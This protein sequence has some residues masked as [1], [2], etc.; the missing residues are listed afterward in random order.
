M[1]TGAIEEYIDTK[2]VDFK[3]CME[4]DILHEDLYV[5]KIRTYGKV[6]SEIVL[7]GKDLEVLKRLLCDV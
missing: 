6:T 2:T 4:I 3:K 7:S 1:C 5:I